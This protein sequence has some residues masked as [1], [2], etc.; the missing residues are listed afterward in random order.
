M[1]EVTK[2]ISSRVATDRKSAIYL[3]HHATTPVDPRILAIAVNA[4]TSEFGNANGIENVHGETAAA[5]VARARQQVA[6][7]LAVEPDEVHFTS[8]S[9]EAIQLALAHAVARKGGVLRVA[10]SRVEHRAVIDTVCHAERLGLAKVFW[11]NVDQ[12]ARLD[13]ASLNAA[14]DQGIDILCVM[15]ANN[16]VGTVYPLEKIAESAQAAGAGLL[17][18]ATQAIGRIELSA[19]TVSWDYLILSGHKIYAPKGIGALI[20]QCFEPSLLFGLQCSHQPTPNVAGIAALGMACQIMMEEGTVESARLSALRDRM[21]EKLIALAAP[22][23]VNGDE[24]NRLA[25]N[26][27]VTVP[28]APN[29]MVLARLR[30]RVSISTGSACN[31][32]AQEPSHVL[33]AMGLAPDVAETCLRI[34]LGRFT[35]DEEIDRASIEI[36]DAIND[37]RKILSGVKNA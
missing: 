7:S 10:M 15:A 17:V 29:D 35:S 31:A 33:L 24:G 20:S 8:G 30:G 5:L 28:G 37:V 11:V 14:L 27:H 16:E 26:L 22:I 2:K 34:G 19:A 1:N 4:M 6:D 25:Q 36:A 18:D 13:F 21:Q 23:T 32:G 3:D 12:H 9:T